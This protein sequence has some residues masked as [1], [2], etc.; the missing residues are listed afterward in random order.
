MDRTTLPRIG[1][2]SAA[3]P[4]FALDDDRLVA[5]V[6]A[7]DD[8]AFAV[9]VRRHSP[10]L[11]HRARRHVSSQASAEDV[12]QETWMGVLRGLER[13]EGRSLFKT[14]L[15]RILINRA[16]A[17][18]V[19]EHRSVPFASVGYPDGEHGPAADPTRFLPDG[20]WT[21]VPHRCQN[22]PEAALRS[23]EARRLVQEAVDAL[24]D[25]QR[26]VITLRVLHG[27]SSD[28]VR[29]VLD[30]SES[31]QRVLLHRARTKVR[32]ALEDWVDAA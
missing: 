28:E 14:W 24:P 26:I 31:H 22:H 4:Y 12:V 8:D 19:R 7:G 32:V 13:F 23:K 5:L 1:I 29:D 10:A 2:G 25:R 11:L 27:L 16:N 30:V 3:T 20:L 6:R 9:L 15:F 21:S 17:H 18:G